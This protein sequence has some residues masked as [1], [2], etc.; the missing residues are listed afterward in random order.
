MPEASIGVI[1]S[2]TG[3]SRGLQNTISDNT[4]VANQLG[5]LYFSEV[6]GIVLNDRVNANQFACR[7]NL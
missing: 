4:V 7:D 5:I 1:V 2:G 3:S 6:N